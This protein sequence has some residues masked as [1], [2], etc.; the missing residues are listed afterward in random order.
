MPDEYI[1]AVLL[2]CDTRWK[3]FVGRPDRERRLVEILNKARQ[4]YPAAVFAVEQVQSEELRTVFGIADFLN[5]E[6]KFDWILEGLI[7]RN[8]IN[9]LSS[10]PGV[11]KSRLSLQLVRD[12]SLGDDFLGYTN[13]AG[14]MRT[15]FLSLEM[16]G[17][18]LQYFVQSLVE[19]SAGFDPVAANDVFRIA[20]IGE[21]IN[22][23]D[24]GSSAYF[25]MLLEEHDPRFVVIDAMS[26]LAYE[27]L[28]EK[29]SKGI[30]GKLKKTLNKRDITFLLIH[31][32]KKADTLG[33]DKPPTL[34]DFYGNTFGTTD[35]AT[36]MS[37][38]KPPQKKYM[39]FHALKTRIGASPKP[40]ILNGENF[41]FRTEIEQESANEADSDG[42]TTTFPFGFESMG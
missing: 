5:A 37:L 20:P 21:P 38:W 28:N 41:T 42:T 17:P 33:K 2:D 11:G 22:L 3:K 23:L 1:F 4:K 31:H 40:L 12:L 10:R 32:N 29:V 13:N 27:D 16:G 36:V 8:T 34:D 35:L 25:D 7:A 15:L 26:S 30:F 39:E 6:Y 14:P 18:V 9:A 24:A 19:D